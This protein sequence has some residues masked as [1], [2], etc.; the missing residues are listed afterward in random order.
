MRTGWRLELQDC[1]F[2]FYCQSF[3]VFYSD[4]KARLPLPASLGGRRGVVGMG[5]LGASRIITLFQVLQKINHFT[6]YLF[7]TLYHIFELGDMGQLL[8]SNHIIRLHT[9][10]CPIRLQK[11]HFCTATCACVF[12]VSWILCLAGVLSSEANAP[13]HRYGIGNESC[14][15]ITALRVTCLTPPERFKIVSAVR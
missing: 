10:E 8:W 5:K 7:W 3:S 1:I 9:V 14:E 6:K 12:S 2:F 4:R 15:S 13:Y 11:P